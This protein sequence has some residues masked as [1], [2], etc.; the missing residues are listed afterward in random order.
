LFLCERLKKVLNEPGYTDQ[1]IN[2]IVGEYIQLIAGAERMRPHKEHMDRD[3]AK[4][5]GL[6]KFD[7]R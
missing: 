6:S 2:Q 3:R 4:Y 1:Q 5:A 7:S